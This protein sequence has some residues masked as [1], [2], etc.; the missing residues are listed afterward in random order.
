MQND[1]ETRP[2]TDKDVGLILSLF[3]ELAKQK[4]TADTDKYYQIVSG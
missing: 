2:A 1:Y 3:R 4:F